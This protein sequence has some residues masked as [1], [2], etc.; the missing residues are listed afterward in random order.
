LVR[1]AERAYGSGELTLTQ[2]VRL[3]GLLD[4]MGDTAKSFRIATECLSAKDTVDE[5]VRESVL[6]I[7]AR[8]AMKLGKKEE[9]ESLI[10]GI[11]ASRLMGELGLVAFRLKLDSG[12]RDGAFEIAKSILSRDFSIRVLEPAAELAAELG[13]K[14]ELEEVMKLN[15]EIKMRIKHNPELLWELNR[16]GFDLD[17]P[18]SGLEEGESRR[19]SRA[20]RTRP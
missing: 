13:L 8:T 6:A 2:K 17:L 12:D 7:A 15:P 14:A 11:P 18:K 4:E 9:A 3:S 1:I 19:L 16:L 10:A 20:K 5:G